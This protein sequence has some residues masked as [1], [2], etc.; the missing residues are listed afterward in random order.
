MTILELKEKIESW[1]GT[2]MPFCI[3]DVFSWRGVYA[4]PACCISTREVSKEENLSMLSVLTTNAF[5]GWK[6][7]EY[8][9]H[10]YDDIHFEV[11]AGSWSD[12][13]FIADFL[14]DNGDNTAVR[15]I[16]HS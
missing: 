7:G 9:Y 15:H 5:T 12:G 1:P 13:K 10:D 14:M 6:G 11:S 3:E 16:F 8:S 2:T 4:E